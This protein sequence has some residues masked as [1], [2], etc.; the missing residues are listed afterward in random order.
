M[1]KVR[2]NAIIRELSGK[3]GDVVFRQMKDGTTIIT[4]KPDFS[5]RQFSQDQLDVQDRM[6]L[7]AA[8]G[9][10]SKE[11]PI[12]VEKAKGTDKNA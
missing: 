4:R 11:N 8:Y 5:N 7:A 3:L 2:R 6:K 12:Y 10:A 9:V 1:A